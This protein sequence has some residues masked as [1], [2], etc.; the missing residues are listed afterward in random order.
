MTTFYTSFVNF[1]LMVN[2][3]QLFHTQKLRRSG[4]RDQNKDKSFEGKHLHHLY[5]YIKSDVWLCYS[6]TEDYC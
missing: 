2:S 1:P 4:G 3:C 5:D 6:L